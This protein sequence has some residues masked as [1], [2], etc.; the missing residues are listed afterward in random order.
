MLKISPFGW[1][2]LDLIMKIF[3]I[4]AKNHPLDFKRGV[5]VL[6]DTLYNYKNNYINYIVDYTHKSGTVDI[7]CTE[8]MRVRS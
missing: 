1:S 7:A 8:P 6:S 3:G 2:V 5:R 4:F